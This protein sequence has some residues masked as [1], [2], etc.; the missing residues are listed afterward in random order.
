MAILENPSEMTPEWARDFLREYDEAYDVLD[1]QGQFNPAQIH[2]TL[3]KRY[4]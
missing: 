1:S 2:A 4:F 3:Q